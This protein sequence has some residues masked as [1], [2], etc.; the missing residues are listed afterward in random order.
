MPCAGC[1][2]PHSAAEQGQ[3]WEKWGCGEH[4]SFGFHL[5]G[6]RLPQAVGQSPANSGGLSQGLAPSSQS[7]DLAGVTVRSSSILGSLVIYMKHFY[8]LC[9]F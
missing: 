9:H 2:S 1:P 7:P 5:A 4:F 3:L 6:A 8:L